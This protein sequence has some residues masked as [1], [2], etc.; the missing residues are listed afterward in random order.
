MTFPERYWRLPTSAAIG[1]LAAR[2]GLRNE[3]GMQDW[4]YEVA[5]ASRLSEFLAA[6]EGELTDD[7]RFTLSE[8]VMQCFEELSHAGVDV[9]ASD[10]WPRFVT[11][12]RTRP[13]L[14]AFT[15]CYWSA[16]EPGSGEFAISS[17][18]RPLWVELQ[19]DIDRRLGISR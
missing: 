11:L 10:E 7:E 4:E 6:L 12:L 19:P 2:F 9:A 5:D 3:P 8:T 13:S 14:H 1:S 17:L 15:L 16:F 18:V